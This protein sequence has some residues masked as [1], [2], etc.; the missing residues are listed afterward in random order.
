[1]EWRPIHRDSPLLYGFPFHLLAGLPGYWR[2]A[3][4]DDNDSAPAKKEPPD[5]RKRNY[6][7]RMTLAPV[8]VAYNSECFR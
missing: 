1:M 8:I 4:I 3:T 5:M 2:R 6:A 7:A